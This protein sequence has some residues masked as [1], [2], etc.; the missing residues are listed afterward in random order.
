MEAY[1]GVQVEYGRVVASK[2]QNEET[3]LKDITVQIQ[4]NQSM[5]RR[6]KER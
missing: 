3:M 2:M 6:E 4:Q 5:M 1:R